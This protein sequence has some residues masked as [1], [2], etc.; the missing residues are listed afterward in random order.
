MTDEGRKYLSDILQ[1]IELINQ[2]T[3]DIQN[4]NDF[5]SDRKTISLIQNIFSLHFYCCSDFFTKS[6]LRKH[7]TQKHQ[8]A[9]GHASC[10]ELFA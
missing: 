3:A 2:F 1:S 10:R 5:V 8:Q 7:H 6:Y 9:A 4:F